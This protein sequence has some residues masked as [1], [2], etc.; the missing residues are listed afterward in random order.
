MTGYRA[1]LALSAALA[2]VSFATLL[3]RPAPYGRYSGSARGPVIPAR[4]GWIVMESPAVVL[5]VALFA[6][7]RNRGSLVAQVF[8]ATWLAHYLRRTLVYPFRL[9]ASARPLPLA[10]VAAAFLF[11][12]VNVYLNGRWLFELAPPRPD[13]WLWDPRFVFGLLLFAAGT[14]VN[15]GADEELLRLRA[16]GPGYRVPLGGLFRWISAPHYLGEIAIWLGWALLTWCF[17]AL[18]FAL[19]TIANLAPRARSHHRFCLATIAGYPKQRKALVPG[20][21]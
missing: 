13:S 20:V 14:I 21:W 3:R 11:Q 19:W 12:L 2:A 15:V 17:P 4:W 10:I 7:G 1:L 8:L 9:P 18:L 6:A 16:E 5:M